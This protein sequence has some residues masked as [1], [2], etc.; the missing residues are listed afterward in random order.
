MA[1]YIL[2]ENSMSERNDD[3]FDVVMVSNKDGSV[4]DET[5]PLPVT[6]GSGNVTITG[7]VNVGTSVEISNDDGQPIPVNIVVPH[8]L[9]GAFHS[10][11]NFDD[12]GSNV[13]W[14]FQDDWN[15]VF[16]VRVKPGSGINYSLLDFSI[17]ANGGTSAVLGY[18]WHM[19]P[20]LSNGYSW[21]E[22]DATGIEYVKFDDIDG[23]PNQITSDTRVHSRALVGRSTEELTQEMK[24]FPFTD[25]GAELFLELRRIDGSGTQDM[26]YHLTFGVN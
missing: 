17:T 20:T 8:P 2:P 6:L 18:R 23:T 9:P 10:I 22:L 7:N 26:F 16:G 14:K 12:S 21:S 25:G 3:V 15:T 13:G 19:N 5:N 11:D 24:S 1:Q 4:V